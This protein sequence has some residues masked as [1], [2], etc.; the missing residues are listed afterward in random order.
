MGKLC[1]KCGVVLSMSE[2][3][4]RSD[5]SGVA[6][7]CK[8]CNILANKI[9]ECY[10]PKSRQ[11]KDYGAQGIL[12]EEYL[13]NP[14]HWRQYLESLP[15]F[16]ATDSGGKPYTLDRVDVSQG[17]IRGNLRWTSRSVQELNKRNTSKGGKSSYRGVSPHKGKWTARG[18]DTPTPGNSRGYYRYLGMFPT[19]VEA[20]LAY[21]SHAKAH[22]GEHA[23]LNFPD[24][25]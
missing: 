4:N 23:R 15:E 10:N 8:L 14:A 3:N 18:T 12:I 22:Q 7:T 6:S 21:D 2:F 11:Y 5:R 1:R 16:R 25:A 9:R 19:E 13:Q 24:L 20:A 17:Y